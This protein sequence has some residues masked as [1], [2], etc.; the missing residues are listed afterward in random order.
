MDNKIKKLLFDIYSSI[1]NIE[2]YIGTD[3]KFE[4]YDRNRMLQHAVERNIEIIGEAVNK[5]L[6]LYPDISK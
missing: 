2:N 6:V 5:L 3:K 1:E 4:S